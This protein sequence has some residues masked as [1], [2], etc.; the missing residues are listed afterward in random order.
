MPPG[1]VFGWLCV[2]H[3][4][5]DIALRAAQIR[6]GQGLLKPTTVTKSHVPKDTL[7]RDRA[8]LQESLPS[9]LLRVEETVVPAAL[10]EAALSANVQEGP[11]E[12]PQPSLKE[13]AVVTSRDEF[14]P[15][16]L[17]RRKNSRA[18]PDA[19]ADRDFVPNVQHPDHEAESMESTPM[20]PHVSPLL[21]S[22]KVPS[23]RVG[24]IF[25]YG[26]LAASLGYGAATEFLR[27]STT[28]SDD[29][30]GQHSSLIM[31]EANIK[32]LVSKL[33]QMRGAALKLGQFMSIQDTHV[34]PPDLDEIFR[35]V[36]NSAHYMPDWQMEKVMEASLG[37]RWANNFVSFE[38][39]PFAAASIGQVHRAILA[40]S[41]SPTGREERVAVKVQFPNIADSIDSDLG[42]VKMLLTA[43]K[44]LPKGLFLDRTIHV[45][46]EELADECKYAREA[47]FLR[48]Y[49]TPELLGNDAR[50]MIPWVWEGSTERVLV[51]EH[52]DGVAMGDASIS[53]L[54]QTDRNEIAS[55]IMELCL[56]EL[57]EFRM[58]Q[59]DPNWTNFLWN[60]ETKQISLID[61]G[62]T[63]EYTKEFI[64]KWLHLLQ[65]AAAEDHDACAH[66]SLELGYLTGQEDQTMLDAHVNSMILLATPFRDSTPQ[67]FAFGPGSQWVDIT[68]QI[69]AYIP[70]MLRHRLT[71]PPRETYSLNRK[72]SGGFLLATR[73]RAVVD[74]RELWDRITS[75]YRFGR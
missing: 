47:D 60:S 70:V 50:F 43:G 41:A 22:S 42:Y 53:T 63:R 15:V 36:Q 56:R 20:Q 57:F 8:K 5:V 45:M 26:G 16:L 67:P 52:V 46:K 51:M 71:P 35:R 13:G 69:R 34:L 49:R 23:S 11:A 18:L 27:R 59:T 62:A 12:I 61:F 72:L 6:S 64:D 19:E 65:A 68:A 28:T 74:A 73:L 39:I 32:R 33:S 24:R 1:P 4:V 7:G 31:T 14:E 10:P 30:D 75:R 48:R 25:H 29:S 38:R 2:A 58:M 3:S 66:W 54:P 55:R 44:L 9:S 21:Q 17:T 40:A 37:P